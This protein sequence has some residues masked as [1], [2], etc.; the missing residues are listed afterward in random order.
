MLS[1]YIIKNLFDQF[2]YG[3]KK[4]LKIISESLNKN[5][6]NSVLDTM[7]IYGIECS[8]R[9]KIAEKF[10]SY[11]IS[12]GKL[13]DENI[14]QN[15]ENNFC[16]YM[17]DQINT[18]FT[19][20]PIDNIYTK[21]MIK[22]IK[23]SKSKG[24]D[25]ISSEVLKL[26]SNDISSSITLIISQ[27]LTTGIFPDKLKIAKVVPIFKKDSKKEFQ[28]YR[29]I[30]VL[31]VISKIF[32]SVIHDQLNE[33]FISNKLFCAQ[34]YGFMKNAST[35]LASLELIDRLL[36]QLNDLKIPINLHLDLSKA[37]DNIS[38]DI[39]LDKLT[40]YGVTNA[41]LQLLIN[42]LANRLQYVQIDDEMSSLHTKKL[43]IPQGSIVGPLFFSI[44]IND[45]VKC[46][47]K[48]NCILYADDTTL[49]STIDSFGQEIEAIQ[50]NISKELQN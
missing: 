38:H 24:H 17:T 27:S 18:Q 49:N 2:K 50:R 12:V 40:Y 25:G 42:Y 39:L 36:S 1:D 11:F 16:D 47:D 10:N 5:S 37:F 43:G 21:Q 30:S 23:L 6:C 33:Y 31:S 4:N 22:N 48:F 41:S 15:N 20:H 19:F 46:N 8:G 35:E 26:I 44:Y 45:I 14:D 7:L 3:M 9:K 29:P 32:E 28:N 34:Q 13:E